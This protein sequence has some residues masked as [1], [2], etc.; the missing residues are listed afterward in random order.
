MR[1][2]KYIVFWEVLPFVSESVVDEIIR[3][4]NIDI[5]R[6]VPTDSIRS[7]LRMDDSGSILGIGIR[8][9]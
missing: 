6:K 1:R 2:L 8:I 4:V 7:L 3:H 5:A 9:N